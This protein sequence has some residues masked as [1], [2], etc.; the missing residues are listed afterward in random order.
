MVHYPIYVISKGRSDV[1][2]TAKFLIKDGVKFSIVVEPQEY[3]LYRANFPNADI[4]VLPFSNLGLGGIPARNWCWEDSIKKGFKKHFIVDDNILGM[5]IR[6]K[7]RRLECESEAAFITT[8]R[9]S[10]RYT[11]LAIAGLNYS[12]FATESSKMPPFVL[13]CHVYS[14]LLIRNEIPYRWRGRYNED[15][16]L[17][18]QVLSG[19]YC[20]ALLNAFLIKKMP[21]MTMKGG[22]SAELYKGDGRLKMARSLERVWPKVVETRKKFKRPQHHIK[23]TWGKFD[24]KLIPDPDYIAPTEPVKFDIEKTKSE[25]KSPVL[26]KIYDDIKCGIKNG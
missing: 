13:N 4:L 22:N 24:T 21:T 20:T 9:F 5:Y 26:Q 16:D 23:F 11:N 10:D 7:G 1:C 14:F 6:F 19:G 17:C 8:Q 18:L 15:T 25:I 3:D 2:L 12:M